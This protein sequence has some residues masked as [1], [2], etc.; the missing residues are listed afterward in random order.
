VRSDALCIG[1]AHHDMNMG[2]RIN[3]IVRPE[4]TAASDAEIVV[5]SG[6][7]TVRYVGTLKA[8]DLVPRKGTIYVR[9]EDHDD[10][11]YATDPWRPSVVFDGPFD[12]S[13]I[14]DVDSGQVRLLDCEGR[15]AMEARYDSGAIVHAR[16]MPTPD[17]A[18]DIH[19]FD[20]ARGLW[21]PASGVI[22]LGPGM[23]ML[24]CRWAI[25]DA[26]QTDDEASYS[27]PN[28][29]T[30]SRP[31]GSRTPAALITP[32]ERLDDHR[33]GLMEQAWADRVRNATTCWRA[34]LGA[35][36]APDHGV[37]RLLGR[38]TF[39]FAVW[40]RGASSPIVV[41]WTHALIVS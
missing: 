29:V 39:R 13:F 26:F 12:V 11:A 3:D 8:R 33:R 28:D 38:S 36:D 22:H 14:W 23:P 37:G 7:T 31:D 1:D 32:L 9:Q 35:M 34:F 6:D 27:P 2:M 10:G 30:I 40:E 4:S 5:T 19:Q 21:W 24:H 18:I 41:D 25:P 15:P 17:S 16:V 20:G